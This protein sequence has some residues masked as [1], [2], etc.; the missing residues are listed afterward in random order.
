MLL[1]GLRRR[2]KKQGAFIGD[3]KDL[4]PSEWLQEWVAVADAMF[5][6]GRYYVLALARKMEF[7]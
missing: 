3:A 4:W 6:Q 7:F 1:A 5:D 2:G